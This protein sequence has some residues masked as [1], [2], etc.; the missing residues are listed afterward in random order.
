MSQDKLNLDQLLADMAEDVPP[1][2]ADFHDRW[3]DAVRA[4][5]KQTEQEKQTEQVEQAK[6]PGQDPQ[7]GSPGRS[8]PAPVAQWPK[9]L[10][11]A[12]VFVFLIGGTLIY[13]SARKP[14]LPESRPVSEVAVPEAKTVGEA[15]KADETATAEEAGMADEAATVGEAITVG[16]AAPKAAYATNEADFAVSE[17][18]EEEV[19]EA[20]GAANDVHFA[21]TQSAKET[22]APLMAENAVSTDWA[23]QSDEDAYRADAAYEA[24]VVNDAEAVSEVGEAP[25]A[26]EA[27]EAGTASEIRASEAAPTA[28]ISATEAPAPEAPVPEQAREGI[29]GFFADMGDFLLASWPYLLIVL[30][31]LAVLAGIRKA[32]KNG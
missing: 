4:E 6:R 22:P 31:L 28:E 5:A 30:V 21:L 12:A 2:P 7:S 26:E 3:L 23:A 25:E 11:V 32:K 17:S 10:S 1:M 8:A 27:S 19:P 18:A 15:I 13:R 20:A 24:D 29:G 14:I 16:E 9:I